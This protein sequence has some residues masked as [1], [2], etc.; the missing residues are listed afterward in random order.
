MTGLST[1]A[2]IISVL[3]FPLVFIALMYPHL[4]SARGRWYGVGPYGS[5]LIGMLLVAVVVS[6]EPYDPSH[7]W[8][9]LDWLVIASGG[10]VFLVFI[11]RKYS[12]FKK[13]VLAK[14][15]PENKKKNRGQKKNLTEK[16]KRQP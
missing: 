10:G 3:S 11:A 14:R 13:Q 15:R 16:R 7:E 5:I 12:T 4:A 1:L 9:R 8:T 6:P 2:T